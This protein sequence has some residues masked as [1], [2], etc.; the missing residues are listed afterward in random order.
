MAHQP[1]RLR[2][3]RLA[4]GLTQQALADRI[5][6]RQPHVARWESGAHE[7]R[8]RMAVRVSEVLGTT[9]NALWPVERA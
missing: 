5:G 1:T 3:A 2:E 6:A 8:A 7:P 9:A 4:A